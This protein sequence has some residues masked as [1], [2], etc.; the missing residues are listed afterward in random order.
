MPVGFYWVCPAAVCWAWCAQCFDDVLNKPFR[1]KAIISFSSPAASSVPLALLSLGHW[2]WWWTPGLWSSVHF[3][4]SLCLSV[5]KLVGWFLCLL[6][7]SIPSN[8]LLLLVT[9]FF[10]YRISYLLLFKHCFLL[11]VSL[12]LVFVYIFFNS[13]YSGSPPPPSKSGAC[14]RVPPVGAWNWLLPDLPFT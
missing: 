12:Y 1:S 14:S 5:L 2:I 6:K 10:F 11:I 4:F 9:L 13:L 7:S 3:P 8:L